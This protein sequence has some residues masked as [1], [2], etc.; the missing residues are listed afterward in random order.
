MGKVLKILGI[1]LLLNVAFFA[2]V[3]VKAALTP[4]APRNYTQ[5]VAAGGEIESRYLANGDHE[6][7]YFE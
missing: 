2:A 7:G 1:I 6:V 4:A 5:T 3:F